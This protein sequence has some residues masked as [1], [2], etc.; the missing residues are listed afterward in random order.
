[1]HRQ[2]IIA[3]G[4]MGLTIAALGTNYAFKV[5]PT[6]LFAA[7]QAVDEELFSRRLREEGY[8]FSAIER[9]GNYLKATVRKNGGERL[10][11]I[12]ARDGA[13]VTFWV[14]DND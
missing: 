9:D 1:M 8:E 7:S 5:A 14:E 6:P 10:I 2:A 3:A 11:A 13:D 4:V 12:D